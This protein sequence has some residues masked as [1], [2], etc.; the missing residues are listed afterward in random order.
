CKR[1]DIFLSPKKIFFRRVSS[2]LIATIDTEK[3]YALNTL[4]VMNKK[5]NVPTDIRYFLGLFNSRLMNYY[6]T[7]SLK[8]TKK[9]FSEIQARQIKE[10]LIKLSDKEEES[11]VVELV[12]KM[13]TLNK[14]LNEIGDKKTDKRAKI[15]EEIKKTDAQIDELV[16]KIYGINAKEKKI[17]EESL[18]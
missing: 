4:V 13:L 6:Y 11:A 18:N 15:E 10:L 3:F 1:E 5:E 12:N 9:V 17:I 16:Y 14:R 2:T 8:S 7:K